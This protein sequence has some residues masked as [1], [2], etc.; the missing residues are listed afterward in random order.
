MKTSGSSS[1][2]ATGL[3]I[4]SLL[5]WSSTFAC[6]R[7]LS[8]QVGPRT[9]AAIA[10]LIGGLLGILFL[11]IQRARQQDDRRPLHFHPVYGLG[12][13]ALFVL[14]NVCLYSALGAAAGPQ[15]VMGVT[16]INYLWPTTTLL[17]AIPILRVRASIGLIPGMALALGGVFLALV[18]GQSLSAGAWIQSLAANAGPY[19]LALG[20]AVSWGFYNNFSRRYGPVSGTGAVPFFL[21]A[22]SA[23]FGLSLI[24]FPEHSLWTSRACL[25]LTYLAL[26][27]ILL[28][29]HFWDLAMRRGN[30]V[31]V[32]SLSYLTP[33]LAVLFN[34]IYLH[35]SI[36][37]MIWIACGLVILGAWLCRRSVK[38]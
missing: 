14:Y 32:A 24:L 5:F 10:Q 36:G 34:G 30:L 19:M 23:V 3:G 2:L 4:F 20:A 26:F 15:Q 37:L 8:V 25:E 18:Q 16:L 9:T 38:E 29:Y 7:S 28:A 11:S 31:L 27:P 17:F 13:G 1:R 22:N 21:L 12:C 33:L 35:V 6:S